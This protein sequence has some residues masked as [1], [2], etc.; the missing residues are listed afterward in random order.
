MGSLQLGVVE[1][2]RHTQK[3]NSC[4]SVTGRLHDLAFIVPLGRGHPRSRLRLSNFIVVRSQIIYS[5]QSYYFY[6]KAGL[7]KG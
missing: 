5:Q 4:R 1:F 6:K 2:S 3:E 7:I